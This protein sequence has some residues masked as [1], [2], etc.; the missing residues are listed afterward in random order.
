[1]LIEEIINENEYTDELY[2]DVINL[3]IVTAD[4]GIREIKTENLLNDLLEM[5][6]SVDEQTIL[7]LL[8]NVDIVQIANDDTI[9]ISVTD[10]EHLVGAD[11]EEL[12]AKTVDR[13]AQKEISRQDDKL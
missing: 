3:L 6:Y 7:D 5:G 10:G 13:L 4:E 12:G 1:M 2:N 11:S 8:D 9:K